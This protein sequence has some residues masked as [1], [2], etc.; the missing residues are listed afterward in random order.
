MTSALLKDCTTI[1]RIPT[2]NDSGGVSKHCAVTA[3]GPGAVA[4]FVLGRNRGK[5]WQHWTDPQ[6]DAELTYERL[7]HHE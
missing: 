1:V 5:L 3:V 6:N 7:V 4:E 2:L